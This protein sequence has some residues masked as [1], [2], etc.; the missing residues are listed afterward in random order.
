MTLRTLKDFEKGGLSLDDI[1]Q[2]AIKWVKN[3][4]EKKKELETKGA[5]WY[6]KGYEHALVDFHNITEEDLQ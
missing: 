3:K 4:R 5:N 2:E 1:R 6:A